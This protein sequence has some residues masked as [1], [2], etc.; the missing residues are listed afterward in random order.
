MINADGQWVGD[1]LGLSG[2][3]G[4]PETQAPRPSRCCWTCRCQRSAQDSDLD[5]FGNLVEAMANTDMLDAAD[6]PVDLDET[7]Y[8]TSCAAQPELMVQSGRGVLLGRRRNRT[9]RLGEKASEASGRRW[10]RRSAR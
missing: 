10:C 1:P 8:Q 7:A 3:Q 2:P 5:G 9:A 6:K 4:L